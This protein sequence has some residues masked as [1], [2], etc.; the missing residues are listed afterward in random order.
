M[1]RE[2]SPLRKKALKLWLDSKRTLTPAAIGRALNVSSAMVRKWKCLDKWDELPEGPR[3]P[4]AP[5]GNKNAKGKGAPKGNKNAFKNGSY[6]VI[7][8]DSLEWVERMLLFE[9]DTDPIGQINN[10]IR[11]LEIRERRMLQLRNKILDGWDGES[12]QTTSEPFRHRK[13]GDIPEFDAEGNL[14]MV[15]VIEPVMMEVERKT[16]KHPVLERILNIEDALTR[17]QDKKAKLIDLKQKLS[18]K[19]LSEEEARLRIEKL[20]LENKALAAKEW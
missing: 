3:K 1:S 17:V 4:G 11:L 18:M 7:W 10:E 6:A 12:V 5:K 20:R 16:K 2:R 14:T 9:V 13:R 8:E 19:E 15:P